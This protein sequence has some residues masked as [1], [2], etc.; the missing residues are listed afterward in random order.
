MQAFVVV[1]L[2]S[3][4]C[5]GA[6]NPYSRPSVHFFQS[7]VPS[8]FYKPA[9]TI[10]VAKPHVAAFAN[11]FQKDEIVPLKEIPVE[12][13][14]IPLA[15]AIQPVLSNFHDEPAIFQVEHTDKMDAPNSLQLDAANSVLPN[16][17]VPSELEFEAEDNENVIVVA[18]EDEEEDNEYIP[19]PSDIPG[20]SYADTPE[21]MSA[22]GIDTRFVDQGILEDSFLLVVSYG[23]I[24]FAESR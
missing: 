20:L 7:E 18:M 2:A 13:V 1:L 5:L 15:I 4:F 24:L 22:L 9:E 16:K 6:A 12:E 8:S 10:T 19:S 14:A 3:C 21:K 17:E 23:R 11:I